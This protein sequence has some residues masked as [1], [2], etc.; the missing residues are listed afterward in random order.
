M[1]R[2]RSDEDFSVSVVVPAFNEE[3]N[4]LELYIALKESLSRCTDYEIIFVDDGSVDGTLSQIIEFHKT[5]PNVQYVS[6]SRNFGHQCAL[7]AGLDLARGDCVISMDADMQ[8][9]PELIHKFLEKWRQGYDVVNS[10]RLTP[11]EQSRFKALT[12]RWFYKFLNA[13]SEL[14][15]EEGAAD[16][17]LMDRKV[18][19]KI[20]NINE[21]SL[22]LRGL[23]LWV[24]F[25][26][27]W[28][29]YQPN[30]RHS[31]KSKYTLWRMLGLALDGITSSS[32][33]PLRVSFL[34]GLIISILAFGYA[35][36]ALY[37]NLFFGS[38]ITG[39]TSLLLSVLLLGGVMLIV[40]GIVGEYLG[41]VVQ[42]VKRRP[43]YII[44]ESSLQVRQPDDH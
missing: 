9:P 1:K 44:N 2:K 18:V 39:W 42:D 32:I 41:K 15:F 4:L 28:I 23:I 30:N 37:A 24:G 29:S 19:D 8:H 27:T 43:L 17:R 6:L 38:T 22:F 5:D 40:L 34:L 12:S 31:G 26:Q 13:I 33:K 36:F 20:K 7:K 3:S 35:I 21:N 10:K 11:K 14:H 25:N 16:F